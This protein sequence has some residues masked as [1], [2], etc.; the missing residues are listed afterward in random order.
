MTECSKLSHPVLLTTVLEVQEAIEDAGSHGEIE[1]IKTKNDVWR[2]DVEKGLVE[3]FQQGRA[4]DAW[5]K[6][7]D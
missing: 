1:A 3:T 2:Q 6:T 4:E 5:D 7:I